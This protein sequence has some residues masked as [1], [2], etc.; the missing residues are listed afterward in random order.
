MEFN[1]R[2]TEG[3]I[4]STGLRETVLVYVT[5]ATMEQLAKAAYKTPIHAQ[6]Y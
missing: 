2:A 3:A 5:Q 4:V 1:Y 6:V